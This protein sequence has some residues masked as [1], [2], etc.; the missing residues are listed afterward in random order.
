MSLLFLTVLCLA[1]SEDKSVLLFCKNGIYILGI[2][3]QLLFHKNDASGELAL[4]SC[5]CQAAEIMN[6]YLLAV[7]GVTHTLYAY[8]QSE[9]DVVIMMIIVVKKFLLLRAASSPHQNRGFKCEN[10][11]IFNYLTRI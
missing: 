11:P 10:H 3:S 4:D 2:D 7:S 9:F 6:S 8:N 1:A 5:P